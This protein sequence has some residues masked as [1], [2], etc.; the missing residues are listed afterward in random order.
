MGDLLRPGQKDTPNAMTA[1]HAAQNEA[2]DSSM[3]FN[4]DVNRH[5]TATFSRD[6]LQIEDNRVGDGHFRAEQGHLHVN[7]RT[8]RHYVNPYEEPV[9]SSRLMEACEGFILILFVSLRQSVN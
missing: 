9:R 4:A 5:T 8:L 3:Q 2:S 7:V 6:T 1:S